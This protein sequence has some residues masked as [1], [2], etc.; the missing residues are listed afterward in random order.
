MDQTTFRPTPPLGRDLWCYL[1]SSA[2]PRQWCY[3]GRAA[4]ECSFA[5]GASARRLAQQRTQLLSERVRPLELMGGILAPL[6]CPQCGAQIVAN[7]AEVAC[8]CGQA[9]TLI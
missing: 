8:A 4:A 9:I 5:T 7:H 1:T 2:I 6:S 3:S